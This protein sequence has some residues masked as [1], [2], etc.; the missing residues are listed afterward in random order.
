ME[1]ESR[2]GKD[3]T[4]AEFEK[5]E[6]V[7]TFHPSIS[8]TEGKDQIVALFKIGGMRIIE[9]MTPTADEADQLEERIRYHTTQLSEYKAKLEKLRK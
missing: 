3:V 6:Y 4:P 2:L 5:I 1:F 8:E 7:Y 9:D